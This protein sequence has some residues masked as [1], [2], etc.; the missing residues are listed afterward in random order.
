ML[1]KMF[2]LVGFMVVS[3]GVE[4]R[5]VLIASMCKAMLVRESP[6]A[7]TKNVEKPAWTFCDQVVYI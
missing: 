2:L 6:H 1:A 4:S 3:P 7:G 5:V